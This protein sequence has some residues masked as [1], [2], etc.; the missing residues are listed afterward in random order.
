MQHGKWMIAGTSTCVQPKK[1][2]IVREGKAVPRHIVSNGSREQLRNLPSSGAVQAWRHNKLKPLPGGSRFRPPQRSSGGRVCWHPLFLVAQ[3]VCIFCHVSFVQEI[4]A[5]HLIWPH[6]HVQQHEVRRIQLH[7]DITLMDVPNDVGHF[8]QVASCW[9]KLHRNLAALRVLL[10]DRQFPKFLNE[11]L[12]NKDRQ[13]LRAFF[14][15]IFCFFLNF[16]VFNASLL[17]CPELEWNSRNYWKSTPQKLVNFWL[18][19]LLKKNKNL[20]W[21]G[22]SLGAPYP[23]N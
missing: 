12:R 21:K 16:E 14:V 2:Q 18:T 13:I 11:A 19:L 20:S 1:K 10:N 15:W 17:P 22:G 6:E 3:H 4:F 7:K 9:R 23:Q 5:K 8:S